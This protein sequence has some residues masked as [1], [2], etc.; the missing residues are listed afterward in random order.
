MVFPF[1]CSFDDVDVDEQDELVEIPISSAISNRQRL[2]QRAKRL[3]V[4]GEKQTQEKLKSNT[5]S[6]FVSNLATFSEDAENNKVEP[7]VFQS[8]DFA[9]SQDYRGVMTTADCS[10]E[11][12]GNNTSPSFV[13]ATRIQDSSRDVS[14]TADTR[15]PSSVRSEVIR[16]E[17]SETS[18]GGNLDTS[19]SS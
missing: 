13:G 12:K 18:G 16:I 3:K 15:I 2:L 4:E 7:A 8:L 6:T 14:T 9:R 17:K 10:T 5:K 11:E 19:E 1:P